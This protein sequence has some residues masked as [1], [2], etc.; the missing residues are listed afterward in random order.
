M[1][2]TSQA[3]LWVFLGLVVFLALMFYLITILFFI[4]S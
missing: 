3:T 2:A 1:D 4:L